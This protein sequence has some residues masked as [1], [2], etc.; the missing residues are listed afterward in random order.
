MRAIRYWCFLQTTDKD[1]PVDG[2][3]KFYPDNLETG[4]KYQFGNAWHNLIL[5]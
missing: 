1:H 2:F 4:T 5:P 3:I